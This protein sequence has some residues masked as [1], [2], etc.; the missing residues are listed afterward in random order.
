MPSPTSAITGFSAHGGPASGMGPTRFSSVVFSNQ[1]AANAMDS[2]NAQS[3]LSA[4]GG[5]PA[6]PSIGI[7]G[8]AAFNKI[9]GQKL[10]LRPSTINKQEMAKLAKQQL[11][12]HFN[13]G[14]HK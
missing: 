8:V 9:P 4:A 10:S 13:Y 14:M 2:K 11:N 5:Q 1:V 6:L 7:Q 12:L 3:M